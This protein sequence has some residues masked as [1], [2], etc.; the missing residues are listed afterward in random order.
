MSGVARSVLASAPTAVACRS[1]PKRDP[2]VA[3]ARKVSCRAAVKLVAGYRGGALPRKCRNYEVAHRAPMGS[4]AQACRVCG[5]LSDSGADAGLA[6]LGD[7]PRARK[8]GQCAR[9]IMVEIVSKRA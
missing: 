7:K 8:G 6:L 1:M 5:F 4:G 2:K 9:P 3:R